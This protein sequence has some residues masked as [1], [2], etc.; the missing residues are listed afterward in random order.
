LIQENLREDSVD[1]SQ[2]IIGGFMSLV[3]YGVIAFVV[4]KVVMISREITEIREL[5]ADVKRNTDNAPL[6][7][8][9]ARLESPAPLIQ[10]VNAASYS[11]AEIERTGEVS[12]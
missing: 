7:A 1:A 11:S 2:V 6:G 12:R 5:L 9:E 8:Y 3:A 4:Y 10:A